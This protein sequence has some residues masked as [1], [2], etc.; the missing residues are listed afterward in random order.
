MQ[1]VQLF[2]YAGGLIPGLKNISDSLLAEG[3]SREACM[4]FL[5]V[6]VPKTALIDLG[7]Y[8]LAS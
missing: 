8:T 3:P 7:Y 1:Q 6:S 5:K 2:I 4:A